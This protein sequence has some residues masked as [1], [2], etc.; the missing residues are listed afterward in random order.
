MKL[1]Y[2]LVELQW[3]SPN[4]E[5]ITRALPDQIEWN[6]IQMKYETY[7]YILAK[8]GNFITKDEFLGIYTI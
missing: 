8:F 3:G 5:L 4:E 6:L 7:Y 2:A 1:P